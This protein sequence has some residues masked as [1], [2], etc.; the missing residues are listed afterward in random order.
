LG[1][2]TG[3]PLIVLGG[4]AVQP[5]RGGSFRWS[6]RPGRIHRHCRL[7]AIRFHPGCNATRFLFQVEW[8]L[9]IPEES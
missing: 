4:S 7:R 9:N 6:L 1:S 2:F 5:G 3:C 8:D